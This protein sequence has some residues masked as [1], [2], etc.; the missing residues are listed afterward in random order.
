M[1]ATALRVVRGTN[2]SPNNAL[3]LY[4]LPSAQNSMDE[5]IDAESSGAYGTMPNH[6]A[7]EDGIKGIL[8]K[9]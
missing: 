3:M 8:F 1:N 5:G 2:S 6:L 9:T 7:G 4:Q